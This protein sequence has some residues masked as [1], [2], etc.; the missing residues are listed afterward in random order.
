MASSRMTGTSLFLDRVVGLLE[1]CAPLRHAESWDNVGLLLAPLSDRL[2]ATRPPSVRRA[3]LCIDLTDA[4]LD[5]ALGGGFDLVIAYHPPLFRPIKRLRPAVPGERR[6]IALAR[7]GVAVYSPH[8]ALDAAPNGVNDWLAG[9]V[10]PGEVRPLAQAEALDPALELKLVTFVPKE[11]VDAVAAALAAA[12]AGVIGEYGEC[13]SRA[14]TI[15]TFRGSAA[16][17]PRVG[18]R[19]KLE[20]VAEVRLEMVCPRS[21]LSR[22][23]EVMRD[24]HPYEEPAWD[25]Y[26]LAPRP[27]LGFG[28]GRRV[29]LSE[30]APLSSIV[31]RLKLH[32]GRRSLRVAAAEHH[33]AGSLVHHAAVCAGSGGGVFEH[34][35]SVDLLV[36][37]ELSHHAVLDKLASGSS[38]VLLEH[39]SSER[40]F[41]SSFARRLSELAAS[42]V[43]FA[44]SSA[45]REPLEL[46]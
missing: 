25:V 45:D 13:S 39:S 34:A 31:E 43:E 40:G 5:E 17:N 26:P 18:E 27:V 42:S 23:T 19:Q 3:L 14:E 38:V 15:G 30:P 12:G 24:V 46:W 44:V 36:T 35:G 1:E 6:F 37:G 20:T 16:S 2:D 29:T 9:G 7:A 22:V 32:V 33:R 41:L 10:G 4:V 28:V 21:A 11:Q 8:T